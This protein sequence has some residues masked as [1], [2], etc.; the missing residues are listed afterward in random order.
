MITLTSQVFDPGELLNSFSSRFKGAGGVVTFTGLV[1]DMSAQEQVLKLYLEHYEPL[2]KNGIEGAIAE[3]N[4][5]WELMACQVVHR[6]GEMKPGE[7]IVFVAAASKHRRE[8]FEA[9]DFL[10]DYL[11]TKAV[12][13]KKEFTL[14]GETWIE[15]RASDYKDAERW[16]IRG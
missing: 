15:P 13:W 11:K 12:F 6:Y 2:T 16:Q 8:A 5:H 3:A 9:A 7:P 10:M 1:R 14:N 4:R